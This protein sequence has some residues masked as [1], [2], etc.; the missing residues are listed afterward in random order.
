MPGSSQLPRP[1]CLRAFVAN[2][3]VSEA[4]RLLTFVNVKKTPALISLAIIA[5]TVALTFYLSQRSKEKALTNWQLVSPA[6]IAVFETSKPEALVRLKTDTSGL[7]DLIIAAGAGKTF[8]DPYLFAFQ[9]VGKEIGWA[10]VLPKAFPSLLDTLAKQKAVVRA[11]MYEGKTIHD[12]YRGEKPVF[13]LTLIDGIWTV[14]RYPILV[15]AAIRQNQNR[16]RNFKNVYTSLFGLPIVKQDDG[17]FYLGRVSAIKR[18]QELLPLPLSHAMVLDMRW[19]DQVLMGN[20]FAIDTSMTTLLS[21]FDEQKPVALELRRLI[22]DDCQSVIHLGFS[23]AAAWFRNQAV[24]RKEISTG[25]NIPEQFGVDV[26]LFAK[27]VDNEMLYCRLA[28]DESIILIEL[29]EITTAQAQLD[30]VR[31]ALTKAGLY[32]R[33]SYSDRTIHILKKPGA[34]TFLTWPFDI[35]SP[36]TSYTFDGNVLLIGSSQEAVEGFIEAVDTDRTAGRSLTW[37]KFLGTT[38]MEANVSFL[39]N[40]DARQF[41]GASIGI[42]LLGQVEKMS[43]QFYTLEGKHYA[44]GSLLFGGAPAARVTRQATDTRLTPTGRQL[45]EPSLVRN[46]LARQNE[47]M[48]QDSSYNVH[49]IDVSGRPRWTVPAGDRIVAGVGELDYLRNGKIQFLFCTPGRLHLVDRL[50]KYVKGFPLDIPMRNPRWMSIV[51][52]DNNRK[53]RILLADDHG[54][55]L[56][57]DKE[58]KPLS[59]W[60]PKSIGRRFTDAPAFYRLGGR[61]CFLAVTVDGDIH[62]FNRRGETVPGFP[63]ITKLIPKGDVACDGN[64]VSMV[65]EGGMLTRHDS[66]G[67]RVFEEPLPKSTVDAVFQLSASADKKDFIVTRTERGNLAVFDSEGKQRFEI[68]N[69]LSDKLEIQFLPLSRDKGA[70]SVR[71]IEQNTLMAVDLSG[72]LLI[73]QPMAATQRPAVDYDRDGKLLRLFVV[74]GEKIEILKI[75]F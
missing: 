9:S 53:Y 17:N 2:V 10:A 42:P 66:K 3:F 14:S 64:A 75:P 55:V 26:A 51:D 15:E 7:L 45:L 49:M 28:T 5:S 41:T 37:Q 29:R 22:P 73:R 70:I 74:N 4:N 47:V 71:D 58:G 20:G 46:Y 67:K 8:V 63:V 38:L 59:G 18:K 65:S 25:A 21:M 30:K 35:S 12:M 43:F 68:V 36:E 60:S 31:G 44:S 62:L 27:A 54:D 11:R 40:N 39:E 6:S 34:L 52:Y 32:A 69:P 57:V 19:D 33:D 23:D 50:G 24:T 56:L 61:D 48:V 13:S 16:E 1:S 72:R